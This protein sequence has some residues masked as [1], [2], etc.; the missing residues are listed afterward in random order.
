MKYE[1]LN[2]FFNQGQ[3]LKVS[4]ASLFVA[5]NYEK[6]EYGGLVRKKAKLYDEACRFKS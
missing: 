5:F 4:S 1:V 6:S 2:G 3:H